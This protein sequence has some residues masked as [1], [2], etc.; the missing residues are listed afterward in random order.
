MT[1]SEECSILELVLFLIL[2]ILE[3]HLAMLETVDAYCILE[4]YFNHDGLRDALKDF[5][6][7]I[8]R[9]L[10]LFW[11]LLVSALAL[12]WLFLEFSKPFHCIPVCLFFLFLIFYCSVGFPFLVQV[13]FLFFF[14]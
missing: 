6:Y 5:L 12:P 7:F 10:L 2:V 11:C 14:T 4:D 9:Y 13:S 1:M 3:E 8:K